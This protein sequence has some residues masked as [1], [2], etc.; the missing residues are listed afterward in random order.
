MAPGSSHVG[1]SWS[2]CGDWRGGGILP[3]LRLIPSAPSP[4]GQC[5][6]DMVTSSTKC[7]KHDD[8][9]PQRLPRLTMT[10]DRDGGAETCAEPLA[11]VQSLLSH[12]S[13]AASVRLGPRLGLAIPSPPRAML[14]FCPAG[15][16]SPHCGGTL[17]LLTSPWSTRGPGHAGKPGVG[18]EAP[19]AQ[20]T[21]TFFPCASDTI[22]AGDPTSKPGGKL[23]GCTGR[24]RLS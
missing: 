1:L 9:W 24:K 16:R 15:P 20:H 13:E 23:V 4:A 12:P 8:V 5:C 7:T 14:R 3:V 18:P 19:P 17:W 10:G 11:R 22:V 2:S 6:L 21:G